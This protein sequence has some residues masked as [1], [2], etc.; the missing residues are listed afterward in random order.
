MAFVNECPKNETEFITSSK[1][2][3]CGTD[4]YGN[5]Q[6]ICVPN[7]EKSSLVELCY[8]GIIGPQENGM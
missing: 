8:D 3:K 2:L 4:K 5:N 6:Y 7:K 1:R